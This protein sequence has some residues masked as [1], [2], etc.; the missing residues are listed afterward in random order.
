M[1]FA[2]VWKST[3]FSDVVLVLVP[4]PSLR[5]RPRKEVNEAETGALDVCV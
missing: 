2:S 1:N 3:E 5:K 4:S